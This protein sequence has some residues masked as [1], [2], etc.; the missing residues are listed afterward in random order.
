MNFDY[1][2]IKKCNLADVI[3]SRNEKEWFLRTEIAIFFIFVAD[4][5]FLLSDFFLEEEALTVGHKYFDLLDF[6]SQP[7][8]TPQQCL[9]YFQILV[10]IQ[11]MK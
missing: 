8:F 2:L 10:F 11:R 7:P 5:F 4:D 9:K 6:F 1:F 3:I